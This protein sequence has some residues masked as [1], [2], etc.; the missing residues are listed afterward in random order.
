MFPNFGVPRLSVRGLTV[1]FDAFT[2][3]SDV[4]FDLHDG[5][6]LAVVGESGSGKSVTALSIM[7]LIEIGT[8]ATIDSGAVLFRH[9]DGQVADLCSSSPTTWV[10][11]PRSPMKWSSCKRR[12]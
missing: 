5:G 1:R 7:R 4:G 8:R 11:S 12:G 10:S 6:T 9:D 2:A 3:V